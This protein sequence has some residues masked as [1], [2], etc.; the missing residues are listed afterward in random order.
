VI[1]FAAVIHREDGEAE[2][3]GLFVEPDCWRGGAGRLLVA[4]AAKLAR[5]RGAVRLHVV[6]NPHMLD[7]YMACGFVVTGQTQT[8]FALAPLMTLPLNLT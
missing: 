2:L 1:G 7:F 5:T 3:D 8:R 6:A 4:E